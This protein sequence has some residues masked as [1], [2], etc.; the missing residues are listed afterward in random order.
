MTESLLVNCEY[1]AAF[2]ID[3]TADE[4]WYSRKPLPRI[5]PVLLGNKFLRVVCALKLVVPRL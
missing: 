4:L 3:G 5:L 1:Y 2:F